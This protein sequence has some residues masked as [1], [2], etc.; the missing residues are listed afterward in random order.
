MAA[1]PS[2]AR[3]RPTV[4][5]LEE[6]L[7][8]SLAPVPNSAAFPYSAVVHV[9]AWYD[10][11][12]DGKL[13]GGD[14]IASGSGV[15]IGPNAA[16]TSAHVVYDPSLGG[17]AT[18][19]RITPGQNGSRVPFGTFT[20]ASWVIPSVYANPRTGSFLDTAT[21]LAVL[22]FKPVT[23]A[24]RTIDIGSLT[25]TFAPRAFADTHLKG[26]QVRNIGYPADTFS[27]RTQLQ[28]SGRLLSSQQV[29]GAGVLRFSDIS[30]PIQEGS[31]GSPIFLRVAGHE[32]EVVGITEATLL[33]E[34][35]NLATKITGRVNT[36]I[37]AA[38]QAT[39][40]GGQILPFS[41]AARTAAIH[42]VVS[43]QAWDRALA[44]WAGTG[45]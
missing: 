45:R 5:I 12:H 13:D 34:G 43:P 2:R 10:T 21:D 19:V 9:V 35:M 17:Q 44:A 23:D 7:L 16:L 36:F 41:F 28:S 20:A 22:N 39:G 27:G 42:A 3:F 6:R 31:S 15:M 26:V 8:C 25:G 11:N 4:G 29:G 37:Q 18:Q 38:E 24:G 30:I 32:P 1:L 33:G 14:A 40:S